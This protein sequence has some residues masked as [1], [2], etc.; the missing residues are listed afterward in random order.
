MRRRGAARILHAHPPRFHAPDTPGGSAQQEHV[1]RHALHREILV[2][3]ADRG[4]LRLRHHQV[5]RR[6]RNGAAGGD[7]GEARAAPRPH[8]PVHGVAMQIRPAPPARA[9]NPFRQHLQ[10]SIEIAARQRA[11]GPGARASARTIRPRR[12]PRRRTPPPSAAP[13][14]RARCAESPAGPARLCESRAPRAA[15]SMSSSRVVANSRPCGRAPTQCPDR[16]MRCSATAMERGEPIWH[17]RSTVPISMPNSSDAVATTARSSPLFSRRSA[18]SRNFRARLPWCGSTA[19]S[20]SRSFRLCATRSARRR[21]F[22][23]TSVVRFSRIRA[24]TR[25]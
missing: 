15:H 22:T 2:H 19:F 7:G 17:T 14:C 18:S 5:L 16:P 1:P 24:A 9:R 8:P 13:G 10:H 25:S 12:N 20:P 21:V 6:V 3:R 4:A 11:V 23:N